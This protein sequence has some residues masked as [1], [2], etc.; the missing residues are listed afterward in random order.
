[1]AVQIDMELLRTLHRIL[2]Q[3]TDLRERRQSGPRRMKIAEAAETDYQTKLDESKQ[4]LR[5][6]RMSVDEKQ[7]QL[8]EREDKIE[9]LK[10]KLNSSESNREYQLLKEQIAAD[11]QANN[12]LSDEILE[13]LERIDEIEAQIEEQS[14]NVGKLKIEST[15]VKDNV[16]R[17][18]TLVDADLDRV[19]TELKQTESKL[20][21]DIKH[22]YQRMVESVGESALATVDE[23][24]CGNCYTMLSP[25]VINQLRLSNPV[26]CKSCGSLLY[27]S[28]NA[29]V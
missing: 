8:K 23:N 16:E 29:A 17:E 15:A 1:M 7:L 14:N 18:L 22:E 21:A 24:T 11:Q 2:R 4:L 27:F 28:E 12:V 6:T 13:L 19:Q 5:K 3:L 25:Q 26:F 10:G 9:N 20:P